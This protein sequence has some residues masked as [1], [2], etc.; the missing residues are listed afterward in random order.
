MVCF[1][2]DGMNFTV[3]ENAAT[4]YERNGWA[5]VPIGG[6]PS[7]TSKMNIGKKETVKEE[8]TEEKKYTKTEINRMKTEELKKLAESLEIKVTEESTGEKLKSEIISELKL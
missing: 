2:K 3:D 4:S 5:R 8:F 1:E 7:V 6:V